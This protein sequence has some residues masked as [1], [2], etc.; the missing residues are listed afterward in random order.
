MTGIPG[1]FSKNYICNVAV[2]K[3]RIP[4]I[5]L[6]KMAKASIKQVHTVLQCK[7]DPSYVV[8]I[9]ANQKICFQSFDTLFGDQWLNDK[10]INF[11]FNMLNMRSHTLAVIGYN[12][13]PEFYCSS[14]LVT[15]LMG[16]NLTTYNFKDVSRWARREPFK[17]FFEGYR[18]IY[19]PVNDSQC[20]WTLIAVDFESQTGTYFDSSG[21]SFPRYKSI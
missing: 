9:L 8:N 15:M 12:K 7:I 20:H 16:T 10:V 13:K 3:S 5:Q 2:D 4:H 11:V 17:S 1:N 6:L 18:R 19:F 21:L 14:F